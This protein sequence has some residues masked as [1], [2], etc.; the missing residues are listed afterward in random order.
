MPHD[1][2]RPLAVNVYRRELRANAKSFL[3]WA[4]AMVFL[5]AAGMM[6]YSAFAKTGESA[7]EMFRALPQGLLRVL[8]VE[9]GMDM[10]SIGVF[11]SVF[12]LY[13]LLLTS[14][15]ACLLGAGILAKEER[16]RTADFL[17]SR[18]ITR[19][20]AVTAKSLA[21]LTYV[22]LY[23]LVT[24]AASILFVNAQNTGPSLTV[25]I[26]WVAAALLVIQV[27]FL[28]IGLFLGAWSRSAARASGIATAVILGTFLLK[29]VIDLAGGIEWLGF[30]TPFR[31]F[32]ALKVMD[33]RTLDLPYFLLSAVLAAGLTFGAYHMY[34]R[35]DI[36]G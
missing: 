16:D 35:R 17:L 33:R 36:L 8:G 22:V 27:L 19:A 13:F 21:A 29:T 2:R 5:V 9:P 14:V 11:Y 15:H 31:Y 10:N 32:D 28:S 30:L 18:P 4:A 6:K 23:N 1:V 25:P 24:F 34:S 12:F 3:V 20:Q 7:N 26:A